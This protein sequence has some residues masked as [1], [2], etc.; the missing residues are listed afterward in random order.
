LIAQFHLDNGQWYN[1]SSLLQFFL[2]QHDQS[3][4]LHSHHDQQERSLYLVYI[5]NKK[6]DLGLIVNTHWDMHDILWLQPVQNDHFHR[7]HRYNFLHQ[8]QFVLYQIRNESIERY[9][10][11]LYGLEDIEYN[12]DVQQIWKNNSEGTL[13]THHDQHHR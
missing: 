3:C 7:Y 2:S 8:I 4:N 1:L 5:S 11:W 12:Y 9:Q 13:H 10:Q 6:L